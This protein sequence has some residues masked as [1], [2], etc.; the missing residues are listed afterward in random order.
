MIPFADVAPGP[1]E[2]SGGLC[3]T[4]ALLIPMF[5]V[6]FFL[7]QRIFRGPGVIF[8]D[9]SGDIDEYLQPIHSAAVD[10]D[11]ERIAPLLAEGASIDAT[12]LDGVVEAG[13]TALCLAAGSG[14]GE[15]VS[16]L[17]E[18]GANANHADVRGRTALHYA[19]EIGDSSVVGTLLAGGADGSVQDKGGATALF[20][21]HERGFTEV[22]ALL[23]ARS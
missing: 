4:F 21:A 23:R 17:L 20:L 9:Q 14:H 8:E 1:V 3:F 11:W 10:G 15:V 12:V 22:E 7:M 6:M 19:A 16:L 5:A 18:R 2:A 13:A